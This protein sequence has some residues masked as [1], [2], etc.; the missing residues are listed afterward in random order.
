MGPS[1]LSLGRN[2]SVGQVLDALAPL[3]LTQ[4]PVVAVLDLK[5]PLAAGRLVNNVIPAVIQ[6]FLACGGSVLQL[7]CVDPVALLEA[8]RHPERHQDLVVRISGYSAC[9]HTLPVAVQDEVIERALAA[10]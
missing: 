9:F 2:C 1:G 10:P 8:Q 3:D 7:N 5:L 6:R 4:Y